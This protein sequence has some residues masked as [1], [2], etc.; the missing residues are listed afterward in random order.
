[1]FVLR[2]LVDRFLP[3]TACCVNCGRRRSKKQ[4]YRDKAYFAYGWFCDTECFDSWWST[5]QW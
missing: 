4:M 1:M 3:K 5:M 2:D